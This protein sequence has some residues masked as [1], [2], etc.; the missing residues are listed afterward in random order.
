MEYRL[1]PVLVS[2]GEEAAGWVCAAGSGT[3]VFDRDFLFPEG[4]PEGP[5]A[6]GTGRAKSVS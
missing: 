5:F 2:G 1:S 6:M 4:G 3:D